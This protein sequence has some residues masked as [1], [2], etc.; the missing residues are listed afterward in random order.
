MS[1][2]V[3]VNSIEKK[4]PVIINLDT[5]AEIAPLAAGGCAL[6]F[7]DSAGSGSKSSMLVSDNYTMFKQF[8]MQ[9]VSGEMIADRI[10]KIGGKPAKK[11]ADEE[12]VIPKL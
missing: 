10:Q 6:F 9:T 4:C 7:A 8:A 5:I 2:F 1:L 12:L 11:S 3:E